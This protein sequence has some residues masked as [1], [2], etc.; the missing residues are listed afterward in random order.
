MDIKTV[1]KE[2]KSHRNPKNIEGMVRF[3]INPKLCYGI[4]IP[5]LRVLAKKIGN[6]HHLALQLW[7]SGVHEARIL[8]GMIDELP[9]VTEKQMD[10]WVA[11]FDSW[12]VC[13]QC[14]SNLLYKP[15]FV[16]KK[17]NRYAKAEEEFVR[18]TAFTLMA[19]LAVHDKKMSDQEFENFFPLIKKYSTD[20]RNFV[21]KAVNWALRQIG[22]RNLSLNKKAIAAA[23]E[24]SKINSKSARWIAVDTL[25]ELRSETVQKRLP[26]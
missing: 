7:V 4:P 22:K 2:L 15:S 13:D 11:D 25:R 20:D 16:V 10:Q 26:H 23:A 14:C 6:N 19:V 12:D 9:L 24:I 8:A 21:R 3:G 18:R 1:L 5:L 17:I